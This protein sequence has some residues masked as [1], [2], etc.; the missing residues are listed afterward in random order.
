MILVKDVLW[1]FVEVVLGGK[2]M[3]LYI[4]KGQLIFVNI[5]LKVSIESMNLVLGIFGVYLVF[6][7]GDREILYLYVGIYQGCV[8]NGEVLSLFNVDVN[9][10]NVISVIFFLL[11]KVMG[12]IWYGMMLV[13]WVLMQV[14]VVKSWYS[15]LGVDVYGKFVLDVIQIGCCIDGKEVGDL[16]LQFLC[17]YIGFGLVFYCQDKKYNGISD[18]VGNVWECIYGVCV[19]GGEIQFYGIGNEVVFVVFVVFSVY[20][21]DVLGWYVIYVVIGVFIILM[22]IGNIIMVDYVVIIFNSVWV[23]IKIIGLVDNEFYYLVWGGIFVQLQNMLLEVV[24]NFLEL[25]GVWLFLI[26]KVI[27]LVGFMVNYNVGVISC[28][29]LV[30]GKNDIFQFGFVN[31]IEVLNFEMGLCL[32]YYVFLS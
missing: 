19:V 10:C 22:Y 28:M 23:V 15:F 20:G 6:K 25:Y 1:V 32:V 27:V 3:V 31:N 12:S 24:K 18:F 16:F 17:I 2:Q 8:L 11:L 14:M 4:L 30:C 29:Y 5:I 26:G 13:E 7:Q 21:V 9:V